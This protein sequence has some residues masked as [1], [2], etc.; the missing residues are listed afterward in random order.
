MLFYTFEN[1]KRRLY[2]VSSTTTFSE[3]HTNEKV[4]RSTRAAFPLVAERRKTTFEKVGVYDFQRCKIMAWM[5]RLSKK[6]AGSNDRRSFGSQY[7]AKFCV[8]TN[9]GVCAVDAGGHCS[10]IYS[11]PQ[12][13]VDDFS[14]SR[15]LHYKDDRKLLDHSFT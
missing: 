13:M 10:R 3:V 2:R 12:K 1:H 6:Y 5:I 8:R 7:R 4:P 9:S 15:R 14:S 11:S